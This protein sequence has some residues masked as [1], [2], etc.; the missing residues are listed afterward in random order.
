MVTRRAPRF[1]KYSPS[2]SVSSRVMESNRSKSTRPEMRLRRRLWGRGYRYRL[3]VTTLPGKP[4]IVFSKFRTAVFVD[5]DFWHGK[6]WTR[7]KRL[8]ERGSNGEYWVDKISYNIDRDC[9]TNDSLSELGWTVIRIWE[10]DIESHCERE[11]Q[12]IIEA[13]DGAHG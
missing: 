2:S 3:H 5:G 1:D 11:V 4:D 9:R 6:D 10:S 8:L 12:K 13:L 7:R